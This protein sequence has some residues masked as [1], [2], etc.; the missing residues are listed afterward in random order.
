MEDQ[1]AVD[2]QK[3]EK[4][5]TS[6]SSKTITNENGDS[7]KSS[8]ADVTVP[9][10][11]VTD[12]KEMVADNSSNTDVQQK[13]IEQVEY[14]FGDIN[15]PRDRFL[16]EE[17][18]KDDGWVQLTTMLKFKRLAQI[19][20]D[21]KIIGESLKLSKL[22]QVSEDGSKI[23]RN[24]EAPLPENSLEYWQVV[25]RRTV[26]IK[27]FGRDTKLDDILNFVKQFGS[28]ENVMM[29]REKSEKRAFKG[30]VFVTYKNQEIAEA[31]VN[32]DTKQFNGNELLKMMQN[33]YW[34]NKQKELKEK[35]LAARAAKQAKKK[36]VEAETKKNLEMV[37]FVRGLVLSVENIPKE[38][39]DLAKL[40]DFFKQ[41]GDVQYVVYEKGDEK[42]QIRFGGEENGA[43]IAW[44]VATEKGED[45]KVM[46]GGNELKG[47]VLEGEE[48][49]EYWNNFSKKKADK[50][51][52]IAKNRRGTKVR[53]RGRG[54]NG[55]RNG[56][57]RGEKRSA[58]EADNT[59]EKKLRK[60][61]SENEE[62]KKAT[63]TVF[64]DSD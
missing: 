62:Q 43:A 20:S 48:E 37:H 31:F 58:E 21:P 11:N 55:P 49:E 29:R 39:C 57:T 32:S 64:A 54:R 14:Y 12:L 61:I 22:I 38:D 3:N 24:P 2:S 4:L 63:K 26:Y 47:T 51:A 50:Q 30:S 13:I 34:A 19:S 56:V 40:K 53:G 9:S 18:K 5:T 35:R 17:I 45:G 60:T 6:A 46:F 52:R 15:L 7:E 41:F 25:K 1:E 23:R 36:A 8:D 16:Q 33:D 27:G 10:D 42:A 44:K 28:V 59:P